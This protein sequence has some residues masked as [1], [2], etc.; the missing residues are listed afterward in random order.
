MENVGKSFILEKKLSLL[1]YIILY[2]I[3]RDSKD[4][5]FLHDVKHEKLFSMNVS[6]VKSN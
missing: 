6:E 2:Y 5:S 3:Y 4:K 1:L